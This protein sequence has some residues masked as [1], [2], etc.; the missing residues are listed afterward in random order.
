MAERKYSVAEIDDMRDSI[1]WSYPSDTAFYAKERDADI[2]NRLRTYMQNG[3]D[4]EELREMRKQASDADYARQELYQ[5]HR[6]QQNSH[7]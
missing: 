4:P 2:E 7:A 3:T 6:I 5:R 1:R